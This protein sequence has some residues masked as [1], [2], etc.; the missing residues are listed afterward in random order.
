VNLLTDRT[1]RLDPGSRLST[2][3]GELEVRSARRHNER[4]IV[5]FEGVM[6]RDAAARL[7]NLELSAEPIEVEDAVWVHELIGSTVRELDGTERGRCTGVIANPADDILELDT[8]ALVPARFVV[9]CKDGV[10][11]IDPPT[12]LFELG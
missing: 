12:G 5:V 3:R 11:T 7:T 10:T 9:S 6:D 1:E 2:E 4:W 8:G